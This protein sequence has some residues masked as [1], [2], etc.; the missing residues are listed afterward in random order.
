[1]G[2]PDH[3]S[4]KAVWPIAP[5]QG[6]VPGER[7]QSTAPLDTPTNQAVPEHNYRS[8]ADHTRTR[9][10]VLGD[11][12]QSTAPPDTQ[13][14]KA[15]PEHNYSSLADRTRTRICVQYTAP[16]VTPTNRAVPEHNYSSLADR[17]RTRTC[18]PGDSIQS[19]A[20]PG[21]PTNRGNMGLCVHGNHSGLLG[22]G[23]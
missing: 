7:I 16:L 6:R 1:M 2:R 12:I 4:D 18:V 17:T 11:N 14:K 15:V 5:V 10:C 19:T 20:S 22:T 13:T 23:K 3:H 21:T 8:L 9:T